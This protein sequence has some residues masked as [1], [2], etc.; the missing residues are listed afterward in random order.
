LARRSIGLGAASQINCTEDGSVSHVSD[1]G[2]GIKSVNRGFNVLENWLTIRLSSL[3]LACFS[4]VA[5][6]AVRRKARGG[7]YL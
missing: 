5:T 6:A 1:G 3:D 4:V 7:M 2:G